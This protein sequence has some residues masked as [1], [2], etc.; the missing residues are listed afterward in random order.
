MPISLFSRLLDLISP[1]RCPVC[2]HRLQ[3]QEETLCAS[4]NLHLPRTYYCRDAYDNEM[5]QRF[6]GL[7]PIERAAAWIFYTPKAESTHF[8]HQLKYANHPEI[9]LQTGRMAAEEMAAEGFF[10]GIDCIVPVPLAPQRE[11]ERGYN[12]SLM[13]ARGIAEAT[14]IRIERKAVR[15]VSYGGSQTQKG[16]WERQENVANAFQLRNARRVSGKHVLI[17]DDVVTTGATAIACG[18]QIVKAGNVRISIFS[19]GYSKG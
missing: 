11:R 5:A 17:V 8:I 14:G 7:L 19:L 13:I 15:R 10:E 6:W 9:G 16:K 4:C 1:R 3:I 18:S 2:G 12:Q